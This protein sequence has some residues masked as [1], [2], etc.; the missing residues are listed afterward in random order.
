MGMQVHWL[1]TRCLGAHLLDAA[2]KVRVPK[3][4][5]KPFALQGEAPGVEFPSNCGS[6]HQGEL[7]NKTASQPLL[8]ALDVG[9]FLC[10]M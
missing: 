4:G 8:R 10:H 2:L 3:V 9:F 1:K 7:Y 6:L 5:F